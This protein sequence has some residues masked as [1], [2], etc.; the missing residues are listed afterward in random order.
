MNFKLYYS[1]FAKDLRKFR[2]SFRFKFWVQ[3]FR[4]EILKPKPKYSKN[5]PKPLCFL[6]VCLVFAKNKKNEN[7]QN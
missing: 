5:R 4:C 7:F 6:G 3:V 2:K 1:K